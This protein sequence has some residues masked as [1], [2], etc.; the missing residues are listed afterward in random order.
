MEGDN[1]S[2]RKRGFSSPKPS[3]FPSTAWGCTPRPAASRCAAYRVLSCSHRS[4]FCTL[5]YQ[6]SSKLAAIIRPRDSGKCC[7]RSPPASRC[8][9]KC[10]PRSLTR[11]RNS[12][13]YRPRP[14]MRPRSFES[15]NPSPPTRPR[16]SGTSHPTASRKSGKYRPRSPMASRRSENTYLVRK[17]M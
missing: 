3:P 9:G 6:K 15:C 10:L 2:T 7:P 16:T 4:H 8:S 12:G 13:K 1:P 17:I 5:R 11:P 14:P